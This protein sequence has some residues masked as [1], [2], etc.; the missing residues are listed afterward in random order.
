M[1]LQ[2]EQQAIRE[3]LDLF[4]DWA[5][6]SAN[7]IK[8]RALPA[9]GSGRRYY[10]LQ[11]GKLTAIGTWNK[12]V[13][14]N[15]SFIAL[16]R[17]FAKQGIPVPEVYA[18]GKSEQCYLQM[19]LGDR[20][21]Y[22][23]L[24]REKKPEAALPEE[25]EGFYRKALLLL[26]R[27]QVEGS[28]GLDF[29]KVCYPIHAFDKRAMLFDLN[30]FK[31]YFL[32][33]FDLPFDELALERDFNRLTDK[34]EGNPLR[35]F[36]HRDYQSRNLMLFDGGM[37]VIDFQGGRRGD[38]T[39]D[40]AALLWQAKAQIPHE[41]KERLFQFYADNSEVKIDE[42]HYLLMV[43][44]RSL[45]VL[46]AY[47][48]RGKIEGKEHFYQSILP[49]LDNVKYLLSVLNVWPGLPAL[50]AVLQRAVE[51]VPSKLSLKETEGEAVGIPKTV[52]AH[53]LLV[54]VGSFSYKRGLPE[55]PT[56]E[57]GGGFVFDCRFLDNPG[58]LAAYK[59][60][61]GKDA[62]VQQFLWEREETRRFFDRVKALVDE[63]VAKYQSRGFQSLQV[64]FGCTGGQHRSVFMAEMLAAHLHTKAGVEVS[65]S[66]REKVAQ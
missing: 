11:A 48:R 29:E 35:F 3:L 53:N 61:T 56:R 42:G 49:A 1:S 19:D 27:L 28:K 46:G 17:H 63:T 62:A 38:P 54:Y 64:Y 34:M 60:L 9:S 4:A 6:L 26:L 65:L 45:Q 37:Y 36:Q 15:R 32:N 22:D 47:G 58:R 25:I 51:E 39:Y 57:H 30:Y 31:Y 21:L 14:E 33:I 55:D 13:R 50:R 52:E 24:P 10:R 20:R 40:V 43:L 41:Q 44:L 18:V 12:D 2:E 8:V 23:L 7:E 16:A 66:H 59:E 5:G